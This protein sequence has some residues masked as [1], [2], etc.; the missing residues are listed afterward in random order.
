MPYIMGLMSKY[1]SPLTPIPPN[2]TEKLAKH[3]QDV[4]LIDV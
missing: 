1:V 2:G 4:A 3:G